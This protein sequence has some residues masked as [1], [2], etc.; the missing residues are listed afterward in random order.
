MNDREEIAEL[1]KKRYKLSDIQVTNVLEFA[2]SLS[3]ARSK[4]NDFAIAHYLNNL[5]IG[6]FEMVA[7]HSNTPDTTAINRSYILIVYEL[8]KLYER[9]IELK[10][11]NE[12]ICWKSFDRL[13][14]IHNDLGEYSYFTNGE[15]GYEHNAQVNRLCIINGKEAPDFSPE[16]KKLINEA[17][18]NGKA[19]YSELEEED[20]PVPDGR[21][22]PSYILTYDDNG[23]ILVNGVLKLKKTQAGQASDMIMSQSFQYDLQKEPFKPTLAT[24]RQLTT[25]IGDMGFDKTLRALFFPTI[26]KDKGIVFRSHITR[27]MA[28]SLHIDTTQLDKKLKKLGAATENEPDRP[29]ALSEIPF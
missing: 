2:Y 23:V 14:Y 24:K 15:H 19:F 5:A 9:N 8:K 13:E 20:S 29:I 18:V 16:L 1:L 4:P 21:F 7:D 28:D 6:M 25:I 3:E 11:I 10:S 17:E 27:A 12:G 26:S 22:I